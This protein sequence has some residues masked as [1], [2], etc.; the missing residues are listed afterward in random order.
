MDLWEKEGVGAREMAG[1]DGGRKNCSRN[2]LYERRMYFLFKKENYIWLLINFCY[3]I[4]PN[5]N[6]LQ[7][8]LSGL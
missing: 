6:G 4:I 8:C 1:K 3:L 2:E 5:H 7:Q